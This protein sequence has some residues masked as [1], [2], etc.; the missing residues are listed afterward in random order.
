MRKSTEQKSDRLFALSRDEAEKMPKSMRVYADSWW[1]RTAS[2]FITYYASR[3]YTSGDISYNA[4]V[5]YAGLARPVF[6]LNQEA[7]SGGELEI[8]NEIELPLKD[9][10]KA[11]F[12]YA[13]D[14]NGIKKMLAA[15]D[16]LSR[17]TIYGE[18]DC[19][20]ETSDLRKTMQSTETL[21]TQEALALM[22]PVEVLG[23]DV[24]ALTPARGTELEKAARKDNNDAIVKGK[25]SLAVISPDDPK[26]SGLTDK[27][28]NAYREYT[29][30]RADLEAEFAETVKEEISVNNVR[31]A[32]AR[33]DAKEQAAQTPQVKTILKKFGQ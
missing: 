2:S 24:I 11:K 9:G 29:I 27:E 10:R 5:D 18:Y 33:F 23:N 14:S 12:F 31:A 25:R 6:L 32:L 7:Y 21:L 30:Q 22:L 3:V 19:T 15:D 1:L 20:Y 28:F 13:L 26:F 17:E 8:G 16:V 4:F